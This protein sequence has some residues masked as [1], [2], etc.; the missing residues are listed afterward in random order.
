AGPEPAY[1]TNAKINPPLRT[2]ADRQALLR[3]LRDGIIDAIATDHAPHA[4]E[5]KLC[6]FDDAA[7]GIS[8][9]ETALATVLT[10]VQRGELELVP[11]LR[12]LTAGPAN[13]F[14]L[15]ARVPSIGSLAPGSPGDIVVFDP[16]AKWTVDPSRFASRGKNTPLTGL[17]LTGEVRAVLRAG[18]LAFEQEPAHV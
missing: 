15:T 1:D 16:L 17:E 5:D 18:I 2:E 8:C 11:A 10:L 4:R 3:G 13:A 9:I 7:P 6:E 14:N 12:A